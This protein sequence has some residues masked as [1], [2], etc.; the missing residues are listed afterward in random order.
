MQCLITL[1]VALQLSSFGPA[2]ASAVGSPDAD[3]CVGV[4]GN[5]PRLWAR[6]S[7]LARITE[8]FGTLRAAR[9]R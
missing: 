2:N 5:G 6:F 3:V 8:E 4:R 1:V 7:S 9:M